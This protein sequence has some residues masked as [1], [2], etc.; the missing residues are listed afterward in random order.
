MIDISQVWYLRHDPGQSVLDMDGQPGFGGHMPFLNRVHC[1]SE[2]DDGVWQPDPARIKQRINQLADK[3]DNA[4]FLMLGC[5]KWLLDHKNLWK[6]H[7]VIRTA[8]KTLLELG[9]DV[10]A[11]PYR[12]PDHSSHN[13]INRFAMIPVLPQT[14]AV[15]I[16]LKFLTPYWKTYLGDVL[17]VSP[18][19]AHVVYMDVAWRHGSRKGK[20]FPQ[21]HIIDMVRLIHGIFDKPQFVFRQYGPHVAKAIRWTLDWLGFEEE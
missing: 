12:I 4:G 18:H 9:I 15:Y 2:D 3:I 13:R 11:A 10:K 5:E 17:A 14:E 6:Y 21:D 19:H 20:P 8:N 7:S 16:V 1:M